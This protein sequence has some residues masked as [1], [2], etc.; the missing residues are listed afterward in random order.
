LGGPLGV[1]A[2]RWVGLEPDT[3]SQFPPAMAVRPKPDPQVDPR[4]PSV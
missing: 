4:C 1:R 2:R 3:A